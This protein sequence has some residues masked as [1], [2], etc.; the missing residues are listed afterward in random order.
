MTRQGKV[1]IA[2]GCLIVVGGIIVSPLGQT[3]MGLHRKGFFDSSEQTRQFSGDSQARLKALHVALMSYH[4]SE[5]KFPNV[6]GWMD[7]I[8]NRLGTNDLKE[9]EAKKKLIRPDL[10]AK[11]G[12][13][14]YAINAQVSQK[15]KGD[16]KD[17]KTILLYESRQE[18]RNASGDPASDGVAG[19]Q[20]IAIDGT[21]IFLK[22]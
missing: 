9:G 10:E 8:E 18:T 22:K 4:D 2:I 3:L 1:L 16:L 19:G 11:P 15:Y 20:A 12:A 6:A 13:F 7:A 5:D 17:P 21:A 14:G